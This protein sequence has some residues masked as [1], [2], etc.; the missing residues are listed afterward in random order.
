[1]GVAMSKEF[2]FNHIAILDR[3]LSFEQLQDG[4]HG[5]DDLGANLNGKNNL[6]LKYYLSLVFLLC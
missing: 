2:R 3:S 4:T 5:L 1:V 6:E